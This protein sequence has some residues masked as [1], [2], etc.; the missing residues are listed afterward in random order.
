MVEAAIILPAMIF[1]LLMTIQLT[2]LQ[3]ARIA[4][5]YAAFA[6]ARAGIV[7]NGNNGASNGTRDGPMRD[8][9]VLA[10]L[11]TYGR[12]D[13]LAN[14]AITKAKFEVQDA[15]LRKAGLP[16]VRVNVLSP[17]QAAFKQH[18]HLN[19][20]EIDFDDMRPSVAGD[21]L[22]SLQVR[23]YYQLRVPF[24]NKMIQAIWIATNIGRTRLGGID[25]WRGKDL[26]GP[27]VGGDNG[28][29][30]VTTARTLA[31]AHGAIPDGTPEGVNIASLSIVSNPPTRVFLLPVN[32][33]FTMR[34][35]SN[36]F[37]QW[38]NPR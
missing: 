31:L 23:Y 33:W 11:P 20:R 2:M 9:A 6:A 8:A 35:Q 12:T 32:A 26:T 10:I 15:A 19:G 34:M 29:D 37:L 16:Q 4:V 38:A 5:E 18:T 22:L 21:T 3:Q 17:R 13:T 25:T 36:P 14:L 7:M 1:L 28:F 27:K 30:A 24:A